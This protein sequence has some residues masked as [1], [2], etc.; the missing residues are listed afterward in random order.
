MPVYQYQ[1]RESGA[2]QDLLKPVA[3]RDNVPPHLKRITVPARLVV[4]GAAADPDDI[5]TRAARGFRQL[6][7][8]M[9][10]REIAR[11][12]GFSVDHIRKT[13]NL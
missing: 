7:D 5:D 11:Q 9:P 6:E 8:T 4:V 10:A 12:S 1:D 13:W 3:E 2:V